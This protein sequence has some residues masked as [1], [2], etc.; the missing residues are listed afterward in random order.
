MLENGSVSHFQFRTF[1]FLTPLHQ[2]TP[3]LMGTTTYLRIYALRLCYLASRDN[4]CFT[5]WWAKPIVETMEARNRKWKWKTEAIK[6]S[7]MCILGLLSNHVQQ[8]TL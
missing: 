5:K 7:S 4:L 1:P 8:T 6:S 3:C 2:C